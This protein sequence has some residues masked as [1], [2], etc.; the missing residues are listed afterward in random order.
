MKTPDIKLAF[1]LTAALTACSLAKSEQTQETPKTPTSPPATEATTCTPPSS[2]EDGRGDKIPLI[3]WRPVS[4]PQDFTDSTPIEAEVELVQAR[5]GNFIIS[6][7]QGP[8]GT[9]VN[10]SGPSNESKPIITRLTGEGEE[11]NRFAAVAYGYDGVNANGILATWYCSDLDDDN[12]RDSSEYL[13]DAEKAQ[14]V[15]PV[16]TPT[17]QQGIRFPSD[18]FYTNPKI[19]NLDFMTNASVVEAKILPFH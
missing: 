18:R 19:A 17:I 2:F 1:I 3:H 12:I 10:I 8:D 5:S 11:K 9:Y 7:T 13:V 6:L 16:P 14:F 15:I 4:N